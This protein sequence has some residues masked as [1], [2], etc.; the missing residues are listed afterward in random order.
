MRADKEGNV[1][2]ASELD[3]VDIMREEDD[4]D[5]IVWVYRYSRPARALILL[6]GFGF[7]ILPLLRVLQVGRFKLF[8]V[9]E[10]DDDIEGTLRRLPR[11]SSQ[12]ERPITT[13]HVFA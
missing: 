9:D 5:N 1:D 12:H 8:T 4:N 2:K 10:G 11:P 7:G 13:M 6:S 3:P